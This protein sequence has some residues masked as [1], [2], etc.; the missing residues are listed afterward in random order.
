MIRIYTHT[1][2]RINDFVIGACAIKATCLSY[3]LAN[4][5]CNVINYCLI[6]SLITRDSLATI[7]AYYSNGKGKIDKTRRYVIYRIL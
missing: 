1:H 2:T 6:I 3:H 4:G 7:R 5:S